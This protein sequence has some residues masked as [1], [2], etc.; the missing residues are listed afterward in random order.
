MSFEKRTH[1][2]CA[3]LRKSIPEKRNR[4]VDVSHEVFE[5]DERIFFVDTTARER[6]QFADMGEVYV[7]CDNTRR[8]DILPRSG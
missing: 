7:R 1:D 2:M 8:R 3:V 5:R 6:Y 4:A